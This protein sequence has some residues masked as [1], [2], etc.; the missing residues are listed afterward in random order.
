MNKPPTYSHHKVFGCLAYA[1]TF[2]HQRTKFAPRE[3][4][5]V[6]IGY[7][8]GIKGYKL[9][10]LNTEKI[11][12]SKDVVFNEDIFPFHTS[13]SITSPS[14]DSVLDDHS[15]CLPIV[16]SDNTFLSPPNQVA[17]HFLD[18]SSF[19]NSIPTIPLLDTL[20]STSKD[21]SQPIPL[22]NFAPIP[23]ESL[24]Y[25]L[26]SS[27]FPSTKTN[28]PLCSSP[29]DSTLPVRKSTR[30]KQFPSYLQDYHYLLVSS[31]SS[32]PES[33][34][35]G[36]PYLIQQSISYSH[37]SHSQESISLA[38]S[39]PVESHF[40]HDAVK[41]SQWCD[42]MAKEIAALEENHTWILTPLS[43]GK[44]PISCK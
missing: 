9:F 33:H 24:V 2:S 31:F 23:I 3:K 11:F 35:S 34:L 16:F 42:A 40:Y 41:S 28:L 30:T 7:P 14:V 38:I 29:I 43:A 37:L 39:T 27:V 25:T 13:T 5:C 22:P 18:S 10:D 1:S 8:F 21:S 19:S 12:I 15:P 20:H 6:F 4:S 26:P 32:S 36:T 17:P 44:Q